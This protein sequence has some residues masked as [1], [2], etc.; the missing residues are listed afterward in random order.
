V[1]L[2]ASWAALAQPS[3]RARVQ[4]QGDAAMTRL[5]EA[6]AHAREPASVPPSPDLPPAPS[7]AARRQMLGALARRASLPAIDG[8]ARTAF[9]SGKMAMAAERAAQ[10]RRLRQALG[11]EPAEADAIAKASAPS[12]TRSWVPLLFVSSAMPLPVLRAYAAQLAPVRGV[13]VF[14]GMPGGLHKVAPMA[15]LAAAMLRID[16]GC[17]G[18]G[19]AMRDVQVIVD[20]IAFRQHGVGRVPALAMIPSD[21]TRAY[22]ER[23]EGSP[24]ARHLVFGDSALSGLLEEYARLGGGQEVHDVQ[25]LLAAR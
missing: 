25:A 10:A 6:L 19:C 9:A 21:P 17:E 5:G 8:R 22:C 16:P 7:Q 12:P 1:A 14:R 11:L 20:P 15:K 24:R 2:A 13:L 23:D 18:P 4:A 3:A